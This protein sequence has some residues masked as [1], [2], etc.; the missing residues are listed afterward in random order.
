MKKV[1]L[2]VVALLMSC[3]SLS[4]QLYRPVDTVW[5]K[6]TYPEQ[7][8]YGAFI[9]KGTQLAT[10][11]TGRVHIFNAQN[12]EETY[13]QDLGD[14][15]ANATINGKDYLFISTGDTLIQWDVETKQLTAIYTDTLL[16][17]SQGQKTGKFI[18]SV[19]VVPSTNR[20]AIGFITRA[21]PSTSHMIIVN[22]Y[23]IGSNTVLKTL[24]SNSPSDL[25]I[26]RYSPDGKY[27]AFARNLV[28]SYSITLYTTETWSGG[29]KDIFT[30]GNQTQ[31]LSGMEFSPDSKLLAA[32]MPLEKTVRIWD[33]EKRTL[34]KTYSPN[35]HHPE[36][37]K[38]LSST[39]LAV[40]CMYDIG[41]FDVRVDTT[42]FIWNL[43]H[44]NYDID[45]DTVGKMVA[46]SSS[47]GVIVF[48]DNAPSS[49]QRSYND[50][51]TEE[52]YPNPTDGIS[53]LKGI[54]QKYTSFQLLDNTGKVLSEGALNSNIDNL[55]DVRLNTSML[56]QGVYFIRLHSSKETKTLKL[57]KEQ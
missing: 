1:L 20:I 37:P 40:A 4:A 33:V 11:S 46:V 29:A 38:F 55:N 39:K 23:P 31:Y 34:L 27:L 22:V 56:S 41:M 10:S 30:L 36:C 44:G 47:L 5:R 6:Y 21:S 53:L 42:L 52:L 28:N 14:I 48:R 35:L 3:S 25:L 54:D 26:V 19:S 17:N 45:F 18:E 13:T 8:H 16:R 15:K 49:V 7:Y 57:I 2:F 12:G 51:S 32:T 9:N 50:N 24:S 43:P